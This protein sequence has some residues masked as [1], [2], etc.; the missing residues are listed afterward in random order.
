MHEI[1]F[2][3]QT[4]QL[5]L[6]ETLESV[7]VLLYGGAKGGG[8]SRG[9]RDVFLIRRFKYPNTSAGI[10]RK[11]YPELQ[12]NHIDPLL[13][14]H[15]VLRQYYNESKKSLLLPNGSV[16]KFRYAEN[17]RDLDR[18]QGDEYDDLGIEEVGQWTEAMFRK[19]HGSNRTA[20]P[21][22]KPR[23]LLTGNPGG[24]GHGWMKR[25]FIERRFN[26]REEPSDYAF[27]QATVD[28]N[29]ALIDNDPGY[30]RRLDAEPN[31]ALRKAY[32]FGSWDIAAGQY[33][34][35][36]RDIHLINPFEIPSHFIRSG[37]YDFGFNHPSVALFFA[38]DGDGNTYLYREVIKRRLRIDE[39]SKELLQYPET[40]NMVF[41]AGHDCW[42]QKNILRDKALPPTIAEEFAKHNIHLARAAIDRIQGANQVRQY[43][44]IRDGKPRLFIFKTCPDTFDCLSRLIID[45]SRP[46]DVLK[47]DATENEPLSGDD[48][49]D[50]L[51]YYLMSRP[52]LAHYVPKLIPGTAAHDAEVT[53]GFFQKRTKEEPYQPSTWNDWDKWSE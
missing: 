5:L 1:K 44:A 36:S 37:G 32:R 52:P 3:L 45:P 8:K 28:D 49:Y 29:P 4:K 40:T 50:A 2:P 30:V 24:I 51:R 43:L 15:P 46:E 16:I 25:L 6:L 41:H 31:E 12:A 33:F 11:T 23:C 42:T 7:P 9:M 34:D 22:I 17:E 10:F 20:K 26:P 47:V 19:L 14:D 38:S 48:P 35:L 21:G 39:F 13:R 27:I 18:Y 53:K